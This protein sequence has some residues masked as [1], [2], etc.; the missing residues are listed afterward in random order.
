MLFRS[1]V[2]LFLV[3][4]PLV[5]ILLYPTRLFLKFFSCCGARKLQELRTFMEVFQG[6][7]KDG[8][9]NGSTRDYR[10]IAGL[11]HIAR[12]LTG[13]GMQRQSSEYLIFQHYVWLLTAVPYILASV[14]CATLRPYCQWSQNVIDVMIFLWTAKMCVC[15]HVGFDMSITDENLKTV[16]IVLFVDLAAPQAVLLL[17][18]GYR[19]ASLARKLDLKHL[20]DYLSEKES[21]ENELHAC[22][23][24]TNEEQPLL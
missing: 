2:C 20:C 18:V 9:S 24:Q 5:L 6:C 22:E 19:I 16:L 12:V 17:C 11:Y 3:V 14:L 23:P 1:F 13:A 21:H 10:M 7:Y 4:L 15:L 8:I